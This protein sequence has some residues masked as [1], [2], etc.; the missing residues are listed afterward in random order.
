M[1]CFNIYADN[2][3]SPEKS[4]NNNNRTNIK[5]AEKKKKNQA[6]IYNLGR[7]AE[8]FAFV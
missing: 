1:I 8:R 7:K 4:S 3:K 2:L 6:G 5:K